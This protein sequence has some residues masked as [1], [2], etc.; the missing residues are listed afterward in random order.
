MVG[1]VLVKNGRVVGEG[2]HR[3][4]GEAHA[5][6]VALRAAGQE[7]RGSTLYINLEPCTHYGKTPPCVPAVID[8]GVRDVVIGMIDPNPLVSGKGVAELRRAGLRVRTGVLERECRRLN[9]AFSKYILTR[10]PFVILKAAITLDGRTATR[11][12]DSKWISSEASRRLVHRLRNEV[13]GVL[14]GIGTVLRDD[15]LLTARIRGARDPY[16][17]VLDSSLRIPE[18]S[19]VLTLTSGKTILVTTEKAPREKVERLE[20]G[21]T[22]VLVVEAKGEN[23]SL[24]SCLSRLGEMGIM[25]LLVEGGSRV[26]GSFFDE[27]LVDKLLLFVSPRLLGD[28]QAPGIF[29]GKGVASLKEAVPLKDVRTRRIGGDLLIEGYV[30]FPR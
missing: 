15:P 24:K 16:R 11:S 7:A 13:D 3:K 9:E 21:G 4:A 26:N 14:V 29:G 8:A 25:S 2:Y 17:I 19:R 30:E 1:A 5:E 28:S 10:E 12:G 20:K 18:S 23:V 27:G 6:I 22:Q